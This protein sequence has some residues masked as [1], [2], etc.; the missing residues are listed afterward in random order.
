MK[1]VLQWWQAEWGEDMHCWLGW[2]E[3]LQKEVSIVA[4]IGALTFVV[5]V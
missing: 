2:L 5:H 4:L 3:N 1:R